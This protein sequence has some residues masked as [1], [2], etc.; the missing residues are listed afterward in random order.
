MSLS[1]EERTVLVSAEYREAYVSPYESNYRYI[2][3]PAQDRTHIIGEKKPT[4]S[5]RTVLVE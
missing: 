1:S 2:Y 4:P 5:Q 3:I